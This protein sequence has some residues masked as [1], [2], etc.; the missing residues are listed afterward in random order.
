MVGGDERIVEAHDKA[1]AATLGW[2][3]KNTVETRMR[4]PA[5]GAMVRAGDQ[6]AVA[7]CFR[8]DS[9]FL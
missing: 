6:K 9:P 4:D 5:T 2:I 8:R 1:V 7:A 3:E